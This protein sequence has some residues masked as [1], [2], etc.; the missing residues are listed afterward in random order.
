M[1]ETR[2]V[3][4]PFLGQTV[5]VSNR[6]V[7]RLRGRYASGPMLANGEPEFGWRE[8]QV[9]P[10]QHEAAAELERLEKM[11]YVPGQWRCAKC[12]FRLTQSNLYAASGTAR[13]QPGDKCPNCNGPLWRVSAMDDSY[14]AFKCADGVFERVERLRLAMQEATDLL[15]ERKQGSPARSAGHN[16]HLCLEAALMAD[17]AT[18]TS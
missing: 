7:D 12:E 16:A 3:H 5:E 10:I 18:R 17:G 2:T 9:P 1:S 13:D 6:L 15:A 8:F 14:E 4:D 11:V